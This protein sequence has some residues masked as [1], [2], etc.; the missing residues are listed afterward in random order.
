MH[1]YKY[2]CVLAFYPY[3]SNLNSVKLVA[4]K[5]NLHYLSAQGGPEYWKLLFRSCG[6]DKHYYGLLVPFFYP[7]TY[8]VIVFLL[9]N[10]DLYK[11]NL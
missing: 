10:R 11:N 3:Y 9:H 4:Q 8:L 5:A 6:T 2:D 7:H 1:L